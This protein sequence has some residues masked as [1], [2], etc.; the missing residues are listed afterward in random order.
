MTQFWGNEDLGSLSRAAKSGHGEAAEGGS[1]AAQRHLART[2]ATEGL[3]EG[4]AG[5]AQRAGHSMLA[6]AKM[7][8]ANKIAEIGT[9][10]GRAETTQAQTVEETS[11]QQRV[12]ATEGEALDS[13][14]RR[15][16][17]A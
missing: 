2:L 13:S 17:R 8:H 12:S 6:S 11:A 16:I 10:V 4:P 3:N 7:Q 15:D 14:L 1:S 5:N 9:N